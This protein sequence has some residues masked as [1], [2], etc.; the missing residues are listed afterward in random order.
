MQ[1][2]NQEYYSVVY[3]C[4]TIISLFALF[5]FVTQNKPSLYMIA[6]AFYGFF[7]FT[8]IPI[9]LELITRKFPDIS[10]FVTNTLLFTISQIYSVIVLWAYG[11]IS[12]PD[13]PAIYWYVLFIFSGYTLSLFLNK[14]IDN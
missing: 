11:V 10:Y 12:G 5:L 14:F 8:T 13:T 4:L 2:K 1:Y 9:Q 6:A 3:N 7:T